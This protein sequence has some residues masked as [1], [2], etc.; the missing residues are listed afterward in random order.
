MIILMPF[1]NDLSQGASLEY[2][3]DFRHMSK[4]EVTLEKQMGKIKDIK[5]E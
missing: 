5:N 3:K 4:D 1:L 2:I